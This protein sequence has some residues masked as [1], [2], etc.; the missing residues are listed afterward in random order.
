M[1]TP[2]VLKDDYSIYYELYEG[3]IFVH[4]DVYKWNKKVMTSFLQDANDIV[5]PLNT[6]VYAYHMVGDKKHLKFL[7]MNNF[8]CVREG[9]S[10][11]HRPIQ[12]Y[13]K[14]IPHGN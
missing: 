9:F 10:V 6:P 12:I 3:L 14:E 2:V 13:K 7:L 11:D 1:K 5:K 4:S 8:Y